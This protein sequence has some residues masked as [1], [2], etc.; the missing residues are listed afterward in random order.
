MIQAAAALAWF[1]ALLCGAIAFKLIRNNI[2]FGGNFVVCLSLTILCIGVGGGCFAYGLVNFL[3]PIV[4]QHNLASTDGCSENVG[5]LPV[6]VAELKL[7][8]ICG[9]SAMGTVRPSSRLRH[10]KSNLTEF[11]CSQE[12]NAN[13]L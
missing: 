5:V 12:H 2:D 3:S 10:L 9:A 6:V 11:R 1:G 4:G 7:R 8:D 13:R